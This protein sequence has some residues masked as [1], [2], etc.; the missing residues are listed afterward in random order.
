[1]YHQLV[2]YYRCCTLENFIEYLRGYRGVR[3]LLRVSILWHSGTQV[4]NKSWYLWMKV[5]TNTVMGYMYIVRI[6]DPHGVA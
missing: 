5:Y 4:C 2:G 3:K 6:V 1:M